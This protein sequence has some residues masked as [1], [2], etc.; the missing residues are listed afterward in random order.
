MILPSATVSRKPSTMLP[1]SASGRLGEIVPSARRQSG[2]V[3]I[4]SVGMLAKYSRPRAVRNSADIQRAPGNRPT[5]K[6]V[7]GPR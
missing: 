5:V 3:K 2:V 1:W 4:S 6:S 7:P